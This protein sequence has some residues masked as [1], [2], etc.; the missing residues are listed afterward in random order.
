MS[1]SALLDLALHVAVGRLC[2]SLLPPGWPGYHERRELGATLAASLL[3]GALALRLLANPWVWGALLA[4]RLAFL[5][6][7][8][9]PRHEFG[10]DSGLRWIAVFLA[11]ALWWILV[12]PA[13]LWPVSLLAA[14]WLAVGIAIWRRRAD[15]RARA[16]AAC[17]VLAPFAVGL[18]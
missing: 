2:L 15:R 12:H 14:L 7:A 3:L 4:V 8:L 17:A 1:E 9:R 11:F 6:G 18:L 13:V 16:L 10:R 5:P